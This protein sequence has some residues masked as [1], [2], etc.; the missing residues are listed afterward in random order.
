MQKD[1]D[2]SFKQVNKLTFK[3]LVAYAY[4][5]NNNQIAR[6]KGKNYGT[7]LEGTA[8]DKAVTSALRYDKTGQDTGIKPNP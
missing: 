5:S 7:G 8:T 4:D 6:V 2:T 1:V 3:T